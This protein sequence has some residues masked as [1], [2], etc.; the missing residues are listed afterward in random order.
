[1]PNRIFTGNS[2]LFAMYTDLGSLIGN[3]QCENFRIFPLLRFYVKSI[4]VMLKPPKTAIQTIGAPQYFEFLGTFDVFKCEM[5][6]NSNFKA[7]VIVRIAYFSTSKIRMAE[8]LPHFLTV[9][10]PQ[11]KIPIWLPSAQVCSEC[12]K[13]MLLTHMQSMHI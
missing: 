13:C 2:Y 8:K 1:M 6:Q 10:H 4:F 12:C 5:F 11:S 7:S 3:S 9:E